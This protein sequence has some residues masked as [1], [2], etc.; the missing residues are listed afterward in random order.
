MKIIVIANV[1]QQE[2]IAS[3]N[4]SADADFTFVQNI[5]EFKPGDTYD[6]VFY[7]SKNSDDIEIKKFNGKPVF[8]N[9]VIETLE[10]KKLPPNFSRINGWPGFLKRQTWEVSTNDK[11]MVTEIFKS[12]NWNMVFVKDT[13]G[14]VAARV[15]SMIINEAFFT[16][17]EKVSTKDEI[18]LAIKLGTNYAYGP[19][20]WLNKIG[21]QNIYQ[22]LEILSI[23]D[24]RYM[25]S[26]LLEK[27]Y[28]ELVSHQKT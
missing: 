9:S 1:E 2:E 19:F 20:E 26:P 18:D 4:K 17:A 13:P 12:L 23:N 15:I 11:E 14:L 16:I 25:V 22:L 8:I 28:F 7:L 21:I 3:K 6:A 5:S 24:K 10:Q 27:N